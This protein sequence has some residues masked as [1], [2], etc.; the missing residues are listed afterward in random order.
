M[1]V[2]DPHARSLA[3]SGSQHCSP[4]DFLTKMPF[5][6]HDPYLYEDPPQTRDY[7]P[8][9]GMAQQLDPPARTCHKLVTSTRGRAPKRT[10]QFQYW[11]AE[12][13]LQQRLPRGMPQ[14]ASR[15]ADTTEWQM[16]SRQLHK[17]CIIPSQEAAQKLTS[18]PSFYTS[19]GRALD[20]APFFL[21][22]PALGDP[23]HI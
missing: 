19:Y 23:T 12:L 10:S 9:T 21:V 2:G 15:I 20:D 13:P 11:L 22:P 16:K 14:T 8:P 18:T 3:C 1:L 5:S 17:T 4:T 6:G 7:S